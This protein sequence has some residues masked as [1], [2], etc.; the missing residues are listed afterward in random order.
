MRWMDVLWFRLDHVETKNK[1]SK[2]FGQG[3]LKERE[4]NN[5][6]SIKCDLLKYYSRF[7]NREISN[8]HSVIIEINTGFSNKY[9]R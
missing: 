7:L 4:K 8:N 5:I 6:I 9:S 3:Y 1:K 2:A